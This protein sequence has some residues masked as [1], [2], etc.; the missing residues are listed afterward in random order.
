[1]CDDHLGCPGACMG[2]GAK[3]LHVVMVHLIEQYLC[4][5]DSTLNMAAGSQHVYVVCYELS[6]DP[7]CVNPLPARSTKP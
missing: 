1:V 6:A 7:A 5:Q 3:C 2:Q 4:G